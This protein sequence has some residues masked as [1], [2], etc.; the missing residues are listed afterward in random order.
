MLCL[1]QRNETISSVLLVEREGVQIP[2]SYVSR[3][4]QGMEICYTP[5]EKMVQILI[6]TT[7]SLRTIFRKHKVN[8][9]TDGP[10]EEILKLSKKE[11]RLAKWAAE[12]RTYDISYI[13][14]KEAEGSVVKKF[15]GQGEQVQETLDENEGGT[16]N[17]N[18]ELQAKSTPTPRAWRLYLGKETIEEGSGVGIILVSPEEKMHS[19]AIRLKFNASNHV[20]DCKA[21][22]AGID[23]SANQGMKDLSRKRG[24]ILL[25]LVFYLV[26][27]LLRNK[28]VNESAQAEKDMADCISADASTSEGSGYN[29]SKTYAT[30]TLGSPSEADIVINVDNTVLSD[31]ESE[32]E[33]EDFQNFGNVFESPKSGTQTNLEGESSGLKF[34]T[35][36]SSRKTKLPVKLGDFVLDKKVKYGVA[37]YVN[38]SKLSKENY[39]FSTNMNK[40]YEPRTYTEAYKDSRWIEAI[41]L[42]MEALNRN[43][44]WSVTELPNNR[45]AIRC[46]WVYKVKYKSNGEVE[47][48]KA[49]QVM[50]APTKGSLKSA[51]KVLRYLKGS[52]RLGLT[53]KPGRSLDLKVYVDS[54]WARCK[55]TRRLVTGFLVFL[56]DNLISWKSK[57]QSVLARSSA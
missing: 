25:S 46:K 47:R 32:S 17:P 9:V 22:L 26:I 21:L 15:S 2:V 54:Y 50:H 24:L 34:Y 27:A 10:M 4:L 43:G 36:K 5:T 20:I 44:T 45:K 40:I 14:R 12:I 6:H 3:P 56:G 16:L 1:R 37:K 53:F 35:R 31:N 42:E 41:N 57:K 13:P 38:Y 23:A 48:F 18:K 7:R 28:V 33:G 52:P 49:S 55:V 30:T 51:F 8:V 29:T 11:G 39:V 19:Y